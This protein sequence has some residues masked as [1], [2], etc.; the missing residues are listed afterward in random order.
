VGAGG[1]NSIVFSSIPSTYTHLQVRISALTEA[2]G[3]VMAAR[4]N[5]DST[6]SY[7]QHYINGLG[8]SISAGAN[9]GITFARFFGNDIGTS[10]T[11]PTVA[12]IDLLDYRD[13]NKYKTIRTLS[14]CDTN[15]NG[16]MGMQSNLWLNTSAIS[17]VTLLLN[18]NSDYA[19]YS[20][21]ALYGIKGV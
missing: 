17:S 8:S 11:S 7:V 2:S 16:E 18:D 21:F 1:S 9:T 10:T 3:K 5:S 20:S 15:G 4:F 6:T 13:T 12:I 14:G 19:Q